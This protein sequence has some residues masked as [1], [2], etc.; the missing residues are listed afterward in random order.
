MVKKFNNIC[1][2]ARAILIILLLFVALSQKPIQFSELAAL[3][4]GTF[5]SI[6]DVD[7]RWWFLEVNQS[8]Q[9]LWIDDQ[10]P[11]ASLTS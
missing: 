7:D 3:A 9:M 4:H 2:L 8:G 11:T 10:R 6:V 5:D 1:V